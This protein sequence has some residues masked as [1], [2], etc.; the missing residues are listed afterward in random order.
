MEVMMKTKI[1]SLHNLIGF[2]TTPPGNLTL[3]DLLEQVYE[4]G[5]AFKVSLL[6]L[7]YT[8]GPVI[9]KSSLRSTEDLVIFTSIV[10]KLGVQLVK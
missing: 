7:A 3:V 2:V 4:M 9:F 10:M 5:N 1:L 6:D 8:D